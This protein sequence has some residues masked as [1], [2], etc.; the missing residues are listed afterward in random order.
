MTALLSVLGKLLPAIGG[1]LARGARWVW[2]NRRWTLPVLLPALAVV[3]FLGWLAW[4]EHQ[5]AE[6]AELAVVAAAARSSE[7]AAARRAGVPV[8]ERVPPAELAR[9]IEAAER[10][11]AELQLSLA[12]ARQAV[13]GARVVGKTSAAVEGAAGG[14]PR[15]QDAPPSSSGAAG[16]SAAGAPALPAGG[17]CPPCLLAAGDGLRLELEGAQ[18]RGP[19]GGRYLAG[20]LAAR[21]VV[22]G[23]QLL[24]QPLEGDQVE[25]IEEEQEL[26]REP[27]RILGLG[28]GTST[29]T[30]RWQ[31]SA[32]YVSRPGPLKLRAWVFGAGGPGRE[33]G[34]VEVVAHV[35]VGREF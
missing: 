1:V 8:V 13:P 22:D 29:L 25:A 17:T 26:P 30:Q 31:V 7:E 15:P 3:L 14:R 32:L 19:A 21:R 9:R 33:Q 6:R 24:R 20:T 16:P 34:Q 11:N 27:G 28:G 12:R 18:I 5:R 35:G 23:E 2:T 10:G 4:H